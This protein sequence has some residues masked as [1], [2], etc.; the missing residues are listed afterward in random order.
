MSNSTPDPIEM[1]LVQIAVITSVLILLFVPLPARAANITVINA[2]DVVNGDVSSPQALIANPGPDGISLREAISAVN[3]APGPHTIT[4]SDTLAGQVITLTD[5][6]PPIIQDG[7]TI[8]GPSLSNGQ[9]AITIDGDAV[10]VV[11]HPKG[12]MTVSASNITIRRLRFVRIPLDD[13]A[14]Q[15]FAG[16]VPDGPTPPPIISNVRIEDSV[17]SN[18][19]TGRQAQAIQV[20]M[21]LPSNDARVSDV[22]IARNGFSHFPA[23]RTTVHLQAAGNRG[24]IENVT[25]SDNTFSECA[26]PVE[27]VNFRGSGN[28]IVGTRVLGNTFVNNPG[29]IFLGNLGSADASPASQNTID[30]TLIAGNIVRASTGWDVQING[31]ADNATSNL[32]S[33]TRIVN[34]LLIGGTATDRGGILI[35]G[36]DIGGSGNR[37]E[38]VQIIN[39]TI[40]YNA[41]GAVA[42]A[43]NPGGTGNSVADVSITNTISWGNGGDFTPGFI[44]PD[45]VR[46]SVTPLSG[47]A[48][49]NGNISADPLFVSP[50]QGDYHLQPGSPAI[51][52]G[53]SEGAPETDLDGHR[54]I[55]D[56]GTPNR[57]GGPISY[58]DIGA[59]EFGSALPAPPMVTVGVSGAITAQTIDVTVIPP[60][61]VL[62]QTGSVF[63]VAILP[64]S[65]GNSIYVMSANGGWSAYTR[66]DSAPAAQTGPLSA[67]L[68]LSVISTPTDLSAFRDTSI[69]VGYGIGATTAAA[70][71]DM[72]HYLTYTPAYTIN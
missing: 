53:N 71:N 37:V 20:G 54:R 40:A 11:F 35:I 61:S 58:Y 45:M 17:F 68:R 10:V 50:A 23:D 47:F 46:F 66:C 3:T 59:Y 60:A 38:G 29:N 1:P 21:H 34:N 42:G 67:G 2:S 25:I 9:P 26:F 19:G 44:T 41:G 22:V 64:P 13:T 14:V 31:G 51:D 48:G 6:L 8:E 49:T 28:R 33:N 36:G 7:V 24:L 63:V 52:A 16:A 32:I 12:L 4:L 70:C 43:D 18:E 30:D 55:D 65:L 69:Y 62:G 57:G 27:L 72:L 56:A 5:L 15:I 39:N